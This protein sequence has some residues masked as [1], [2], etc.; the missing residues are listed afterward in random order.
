MVMNCLREEFKDFISNVEVKTEPPDLKTPQLELAEPDEIE[1]RFRALEKWTE[2]LMPYIN[3]N[4][5]FGSLELE[6][7]RN[8]KPFKISFLKP[9][10]RKYAESYKFKFATITKSVSIIHKEIPNVFR[11][12]NFSSLEIDEIP[13]VQ[14]MKKSLFNDHFKFI[15]LNEY[16]ITKI[17]F[18]M[19]LN[20]KNL[21]TISPISFTD[22]D[23]KRQKNMPSILIIPKHKSLERLRIVDVIELELDNLNFNSN[24]IEESS[25]A[26]IAIET[27]KPLEFQKKC[28]INFDTLQNHL[29]VEILQLNNWKIFERPETMKGVQFIQVRRES[30]ILVIKIE[31]IEKVFQLHL[32]RSCYVILEMQNSQ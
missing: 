2:L 7:E 14:F 27:P 17:P 32:P 24:T 11:N 23:I 18:W 8:I 26:T 19:D 16:D 30:F 29:L 1:F 25:V 22:F 6:I 20:P 4:Q 31:A 3:C 21:N 10:T 12:N 9:N 15:V 28:I 13:D 5:V